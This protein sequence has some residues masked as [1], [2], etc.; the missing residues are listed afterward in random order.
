MIHATH[1]TNAPQTITDTGSVGTTPTTPSAAPTSLLPEP[2]PML[3]GDLS[4]QI[5]ALAV[6][7]GETERDI[8][9]KAAETEDTTEDAANAAQ[10][11]LM[12]DE[13]STMRTGAWVSGLLQVGAGAL[14]MASGAVSLNGANTAAGSSAAR[15]IAGQATMLGGGSQCLQAGSTLAGGYFKAAETDTEA[16]TTAEKGIADAAQR[17]S[18]DARAAEKDASDFVQSAI[19][20]YRQFQA[21]KA[22]ADAAALHGA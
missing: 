1:G 17:T 6:K 14:S 13:A 2:S 7:T 8:N 5:A 4:A 9:S 21:T 22:Q 11:S 12:H 20:F 19:D 16:L 3:G 18:G 15:A 10:V